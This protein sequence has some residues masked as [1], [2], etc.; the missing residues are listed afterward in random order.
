MLG[1]SL[2]MFGQAAPAL[3]TLA[4]RPYALSVLCAPDIDPDQVGRRRDEVRRAQQHAWYL[5]QLKARSDP[6]IQVGGSLDA[7]VAAVLRALASLRTA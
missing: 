5:G 4:K 7:R 1:H 2:W 6:W 3:Y